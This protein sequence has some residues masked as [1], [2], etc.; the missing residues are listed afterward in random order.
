M[1]V[2]ITPID[3]YLK[4][5]RLL[6]TYMTSRMSQQEAMH[7]DYQEQCMAFFDFTHLDQGKGRTLYRRFDTPSQC[8]IFI[9]NYNNKIRK[10]RSSMGA[11]ITVRFERK[12]K[13]NIWVE[14]NAYTKDGNI[15]ELCSSRNYMLF[16]LLANVRN[17]F[18]I[19]PLEALR[20]LPDDI[21]EI[22]RNTFYD[23]NYHSHSYY[24]LK[25]LLKHLE[26]TTD[27][28]LNNVLSRFVYP[29]EE[30]A[31]SYHYYSSQSADF[32]VIFAFDS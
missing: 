4:Q 26:A 30:L 17:H 9:T 28:E 10:R 19:E 12:T 27:P 29:I 11:D 23:M 31:N 1:S 15:L 14:A 24:T 21:C 7:A 2:T 22:T 3:M 13:D 32:R 25:E 16:A 6:D 18:D 5:G 20:D 8:T